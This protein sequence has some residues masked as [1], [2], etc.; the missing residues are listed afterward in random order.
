MKM[1]ASNDSSSLDMT[2]EAVEK[3][4]RDVAELRDFGLQIEQATPVD[5]VKQKDKP[6]EFHS[7]SSHQE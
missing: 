5:P 1:A 6:D 3:R 2:P 4:L 7:D